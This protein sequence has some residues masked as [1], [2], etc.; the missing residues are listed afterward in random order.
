MEAVLAQ[1][2]ALGNS[3]RLVPAEEVLMNVLQDLDP[4]LTSSLKKE[5]TGKI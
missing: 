5:K 3:K 1:L 4:Y 2:Q